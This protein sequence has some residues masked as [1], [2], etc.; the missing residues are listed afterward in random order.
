METFR[1]SKS[2]GVGVLIIFLTAM[3][4]LFYYLYPEPPMSTSTILSRMKSIFWVIPARTNIFCLKTFWE[5]LNFNMSSWAKRASAWQ[6][7]KWICKNNIFLNKNIPPCSRIFTENI[8]CLSYLGQLFYRLRDIFLKFLLI[9]IRTMFD[10]AIPLN[11]S[12]FLHLN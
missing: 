1:P 3:L 7:A 6:T 2:R 10:L 12:K 4:C 5:H 11:I 9:N 8:T